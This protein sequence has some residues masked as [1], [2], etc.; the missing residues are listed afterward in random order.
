MIPIVLSFFRLGCSFGRIHLEFKGL[1]AQIYFSSFVIFS[2]IGIQI[3]KNRSEELFFNFFYIWNRYMKANFIFSLVEGDMRLI[4]VLFIIKCHVSQSVQWVDF[5][6]EDI[7]W[8]SR[9]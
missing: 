6:E 9:S 2:E 3:V 8:L 5:Q 7:N 1:R 4:C